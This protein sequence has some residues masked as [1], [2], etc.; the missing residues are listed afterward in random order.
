MAEETDLKC[1]L[2]EETSTMA[3]LTWSADSQSISKI[4]R[5][6]QLPLLVTVAD[7]NHKQTAVSVN[8]VIKIESILAVDYVEASVLESGVGEKK[9]PAST[10]FPSTIALPKT[11]TS[12]SLEVVKESND[13]GLNKT[14]HRSKSQSNKSSHWFLARKTKMKFTS[15]KSL[16]KFRPKVVRVITTPT[17]MIASPDLHVG[18]ELVLLDVIECERLAVKYLRCRLR[19]SNDPQKIIKLNLKWTGSYESVPEPKSMH[20]KDLISLHGLPTTVR[21]RETIP[22]RNKWM[23]PKASSIMKRIR[24]LDLHLKFSQ[25][26]TTYF[27]IGVVV[28]GDGARR[29]VVII[30]TNS[31]VL[32]KVSPEMEEKTKIYQQLISSYKG[33]DVERIPPEMFIRDKGAVFVTV[34]LWELESWNVKLR[35][36]KHLESPEASVFKFFPSN[37]MLVHLWGKARG[38]FIFQEGGQKQEDDRRF[39]EAGPSAL[40]EEILKLR[41]LV[42]EREEGVQ[43][44]REEV[45]RLAGREDVD[46]GPR[47]G[48]CQP[49]VTSS[50]QASPDDGSTAMPPNPRFSTSHKVKLDRFKENQRSPLT[51]WWKVGGKMQRQP[52]LH[53]DLAV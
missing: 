53:G 17:Q 10:S 16:A 49:A 30:S 11:L 35:N 14:L 19:E 43:A 52:W 24:T 39:W 27:A 42:Q 25:E 32:L 50:S 20:V 45:D 15:V 51:P 28:G 33:I 13:Q 26:A 36:K 47:K 7:G 1:G 4:L 44:S 38:S 40:E 23:N 21:I 3:D 48:H 8:E 22:N 6:Y 34:P 46:P 12:V 29:S 9:D 18:N 5:K 41:L 37:V 31:D 2:Q